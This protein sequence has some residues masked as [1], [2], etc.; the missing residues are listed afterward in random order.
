MTSIKLP[1]PQVHRIML[2]LSDGEWHKSGEIEQYAAVKARTVRLVA[3][4]TGKLVGGNQG[5]KRTDLANPDEIWHAR[6]S[7]KSRARKLLNRAKRLE[8]EFRRGLV[9]ITQQE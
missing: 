3:E 2:F 5:Y 1:L 7:L 8:K 4:K 6:N 9:D